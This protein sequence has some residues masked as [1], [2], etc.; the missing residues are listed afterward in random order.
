M[1]DKKDSYD[2][3]ELRERNGDR[4]QTTTT[5]P[6]QQLDQHPPPVIIEQL[7]NY[8]TSLENLDNGPSHVSTP[9]TIAFFLKTCIHK[10]GP[11][12]GFLMDNEF[13]HVHPMPDGSLHIALPETTGSQ[14]VQGKWGELHP[15]AG[16]YG[17]PKT[18]YMLY[19]PRNEEELAIAKQFVN[20]SLQYAKSN[21]ND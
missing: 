3:S 18:I 11:H 21:C 12:E 20:I 13:V 8:I 1:P 6:H 14:L 16:K 19:A 2:L 17:F 10:K 5:N 4:P 9:G 7:V 15:V